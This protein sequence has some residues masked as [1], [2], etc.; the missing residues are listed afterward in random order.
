MKSLLKHCNLQILKM[1]A[2]ITMTIDHADKIIFNSK[3]WFNPEIGR[4]AF[5]L[6][7]YLLCYNFL[8]NTSNQKKYALR[9]L[10]LAIISQPFY[11]YAFR[12]EFGLN[13]LYTL[14]IGILLLIFALPLIKKNRFY[15]YL[16]S[17]LIMLVSAIHGY[18]MLPF[19]FDY[20][21]NAFF[22][23]LSL[24][25]FLYFST[26]DYAIYTFISLY[27]LNNSD[28]SYLHLMF[29]L[30]A[31]FL[32]AYLLK[33]KLRSVN[34]YFFYAFYPLHLFALRLI[35]DLLQ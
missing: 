4:I 17:I 31:V 20:G 35:T 15:F 9:I 7:A 10:I 34:K 2:I 3:A 18:L 16:I 30:P 19:F 8:F 27:F 25:C 22:F 26:L 23:M 5:P 14:G 1:I 6:F 12:Y 33:E 21:Y 29:Y 13:I 32:I 24:G 28:N 11:Y